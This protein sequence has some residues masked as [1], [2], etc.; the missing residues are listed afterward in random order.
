V[1]RLDL[2]AGERSP[3]GYVPLGNVNGTQIYPLPY[4]DGSVDAIRASHV[5]EHFP[6]GQVAAVLAD[7]VRALKP[8]GELKIAVPD[9]GKIAENYVAGQ[10]Q[11]TVG[12]TMGGQI[13]E[14]DFHKALFDAESLKRALAGAG[15]MLIRAWKSELDDDCAALPISLNLA[16][17]KPH[18]SEISVSAVMS[19]PRLGFM[20]NFF[21]AFEAL[22]PL[23]VK[24]R[25][26]SGAY[27]SQCIERVIGE[28]ITEDHPDAV[29]T[30]DYDSVFSRTDAAMLMQLMCCHPEADAIAAV[31]AGRGKS[32]P[33][34]TVEGPDGANIARMPTA[35]FASDLT[36]V[37]TAHFGLTLLR[38]DRFN[39]VS[40]PWFRD[41]PAPDG[42]WGDGRIDADINFWRQWE[43]AGNSL[44]LANRVPIGHLELQVLWPGRDLSSIS[45]PVSDWRENGR[46][47]EAWQ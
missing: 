27:W 25:R 45:Q 34:F 39:Q 4:A 26:Y 33:L 6:H 2:G 5:L 16:G 46:P 24:L 19:V 29:L 47:Q 15:L 44:F 12:Y 13:D 10:P 37:S 38:A 36:R 21:A 23:R 14:A 7:W 40:R 11:N 32:S 35:D 30:L 31:Q 17:T 42:T 9:F 20:D 22:P 8:G 1:I 3:E 43:A 41:V 28:A 18:Q